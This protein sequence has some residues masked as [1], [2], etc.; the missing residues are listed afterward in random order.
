MFSKIGFLPFAI[1]F[2]RQVQQR[3]KTNQEKCPSEGTFLMLIHKFRA[4]VLQH[5]GEEA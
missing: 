1:G 4:I 5:Q 3:H 2:F